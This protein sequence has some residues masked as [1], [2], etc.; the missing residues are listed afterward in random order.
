ME[1]ARSC[2]IT[3]RTEYVVLFDPANG[4]YWLS[5]LE[6]LDESSGGSVTDSSRTS[7][8][9]SLSAREET[10]LLSEDA[11]ETAGTYSRTGGVLGI[12]QQLSENVQ[13]AQIISPRSSTTTNEI[14]Y[15]VFY[16][17]S[18]AE[19][20]ELYIQSTTNKTFLLS[21]SKSTARTSIRELT[22][23][24]IEELGLASGSG[25]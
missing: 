21:V 24:E 7:L 13:I 4:E 22:P 6:F 5:L 25:S 23:E 15:V 12:P 16:P 3:E 1:F 10:L 11:E 19:N 17:D 20:F 2:A 14:E 8:F 18:T 9:E